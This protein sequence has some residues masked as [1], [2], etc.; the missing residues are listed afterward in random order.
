MLEKVRAFR[1]SEPI[2]LWVRARSHITPVNT[3]SGAGQDVSPRHGKLL[4]FT[5][6]LPMTSGRH[7][8][9]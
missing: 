1:R 9:P 6:E 4:Q 8:R 5:N 7:P 2:Q 3:A